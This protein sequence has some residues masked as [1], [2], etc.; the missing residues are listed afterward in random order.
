LLVNVTIGGGG[1]VHPA[2]VLHPSCI[3]EKVG[4]NQEVLSQK[5]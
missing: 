1:G 4:V 2:L 3:P 5:W